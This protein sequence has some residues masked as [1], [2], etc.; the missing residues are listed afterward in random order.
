MSKK[1]EAEQL[2]KDDE[3]GDLAFDDLAID[4]EKAMKTGGKWYLVSKYSEYLNFIQ[5]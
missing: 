3:K 1:Q 5:K 2:D 4:F